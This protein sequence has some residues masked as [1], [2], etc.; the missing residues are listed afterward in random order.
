MAKWLIV[1]KL[2]ILVEKRFNDNNVDEFDG[3]RPGLKNTT[4]CNGGAARGSTA[5]ILNEANKVP[6]TN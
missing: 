2:Q 6:S 4:L 3:Q 1:A 5:L